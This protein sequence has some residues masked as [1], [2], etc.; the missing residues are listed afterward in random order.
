MR[1]LPKASSIRVKDVDPDLDPRQHIT[2][3][4]KSANKSS[5]PAPVEYQGVLWNNE[6]QAP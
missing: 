2:A 4:E 1:G 6:T 3:D 5:T